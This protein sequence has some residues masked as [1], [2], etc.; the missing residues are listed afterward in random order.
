MRL[1]RG[2]PGVRVARGARGCSMAGTQGMPAASVVPPVQRLAAWREAAHQQPPMLSTCVAQV[3]WKRRMQ[4][5]C[6]PAVERCLQLGFGQP[7][8]RVCVCVV[9][10]SSSHGCIICA[11]S[12]W[13]GRCLLGGK[14][15][16]TPTW[17]RV[18]QLMC[19]SE[20]IV[21]LGATVPC[22]CFFPVRCPAICP[23]AAAS[24]PPARHLLRDPACGARPGRHQHL[25]FTARTR[26][27]PAVAAVAADPAACLHLAADAAAAAG[28]AGAVAASAAASGCGCGRLIAWLPS[29]RCHQSLL[30]W[31]CTEQCG[32][33]PYG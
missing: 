15:Q 19:C 23:A 13:Y 16:G 4:R 30:Q 27:S 12:A 21:Y 9:R 25:R 20:H 3:D 29:D 26:D 1:S 32:G 33:R 22:V 7:A 5:C 8:M 10:A 14:C 28:A 17:R 18:E 6:C 11:S 2:T 31:R 24:S